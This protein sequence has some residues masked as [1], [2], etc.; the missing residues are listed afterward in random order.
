[1]PI[2]AT[3]LIAFGAASRPEDDVAASGGAIDL[4]DRPVFT[5][6]TANSVI[7]VVSDGADTRVVT[8][9]GRNAAGARVTEA[10]TLN[11]ATEVVGT[12]TFERILKVT[13]G[14]ADAARTITVKQGSAGPTRATIPINEI[15]VFALF[16]E[17]ASETAATTRFEK[18]FW[19]NIHASLTLNS[20]QVRLAAD[21]AAKIRHGV[22]AAKNDS[23]SVAN[24]KTSPGVTFADDNIDQAVPGNTLEAA[25]AIGV[26]WELALGISDAPVRNTFTSRVTG[27][28]V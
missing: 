26:W 16:I 15:G 2:A 22:V 7:A 17:S 9:A 19:K 27:T 25:S 10:L 28:S 6:L 20:A 11:G 8:I 21:P 3:D 12:T 23:T 13:V 1:M 5:Q 14:A 18:T 4:T 24:R